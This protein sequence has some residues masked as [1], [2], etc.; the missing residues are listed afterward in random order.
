VPHTTITLERYRFPFSDVTQKP[1]LPSWS[2]LEK[3]KGRYNGTRIQKKVQCDRDTE[4][5]T[6]QKNFILDGFLGP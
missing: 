5:G 3:G 4:K 2:K 1:S 6:L